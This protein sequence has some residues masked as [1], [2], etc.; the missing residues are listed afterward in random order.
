M[1]C[2]KAKMQLT[3]FRTSTCGLY[4]F[5]HKFDTCKRFVGQFKGPEGLI[6]LFHQLYDKP[7]WKLNPMEQELKFNCPNAADWYITVTLVYDHDELEFLLAKK[8]VQYRT[9]NPTGLNTKLSFTSKEHFYRFAEW[10]AEYRR[11]N[12]ISDV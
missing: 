8:V 6:H 5:V 2:S 9:L 1:L 7:E 4:L 12:K 3:A 11:E 10:Y